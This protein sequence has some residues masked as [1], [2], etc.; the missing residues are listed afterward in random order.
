MVLDAGPARW[1]LV[2]HTALGAAA[3]AAS[4]HLCVWLAKYLRGQHGRRRAVHR[5]AAIAF[6][7]QG[8][9][10]V[11]GN[12]AYPTYK[13]HVRAEYL[14][15]ADAIRADWAGRVRQHARRRAQAVGAPERVPGDPE[16]AHRISGVARGAEKA[17]KW[18]DTKEHWVALGLV[19]SLACLVLLRAW[20]P[21]RDGRAPAPF[22]GLLALGACATLWYAAV[23][24]VLTAT[25]RAI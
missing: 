24:G 1:L 19:L 7:L 6:V 2:V 17:A 23:V 20:D 15:D 22:I 25:W 12:L 4:T 9:A 21:D 10:F 14:D 18:F 13:T 11:A 3:V 8:L 16:V 5:F